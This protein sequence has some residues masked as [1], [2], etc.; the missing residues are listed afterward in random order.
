VVAVVVAAAVA[1]AVPVAVLLAPP[2]VT[3][4]S[5]RCGSCEGPRKLRGPFAFGYQVDELQRVLKF[6]ILKG[7][8]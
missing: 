8:L 6:P 3:E 7:G 2:V 4:T 5:S 1:V